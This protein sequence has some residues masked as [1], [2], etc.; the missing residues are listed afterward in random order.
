MSF[1][2]STLETGEPVKKDAKDSLEKRKTISSKKIEKNNS[3]ATK[4]ESSD[5]RLTAQA[6]SVIKDY[7]SKAKKLNNTAYLSVA[8]QLDHDGKFNS[9]EEIIQRKAHTIVQI[10]CQTLLAKLYPE[11]YPFQLPQI[12]WKNHKNTKTLLQQTVEW[13]ALKKSTY[14]EKWHNNNAMSALE[15]GN[16]HILIPLLDDALNE[17]TKKSLKETIQQAKDKI[18]ITT[19]IWYKSD[20]YNSYRI[21]SHNA[22]WQEATKVN[23]GTNT[24]EWL[25]LTFPT[26][27]DTILVANMTNYL[28]RERAMWNWKFVVTNEWH[29]MYDNKYSIDALEP[30]DLNLS[31]LL[32]LSNVFQNQDAVKK[33]AQWLNTRKEDLY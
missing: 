6:L 2:N 25:S 18:G 17:L 33:Y 19:T 28:L 16:F 8:W 32:K 3:I 31:G 12:D 20:W 23:M 26:W 4:I 7:E 27:E 1:E 29:I 10:Y 13:F 14:V 5:S 21:E 30:I 9:T 22:Y 15:N 24:I 11:G